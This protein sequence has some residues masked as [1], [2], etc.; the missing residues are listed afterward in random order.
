MDKDLPAVILLLM[1]IIFLVIV[2]MFVVSDI[3]QDIDTL[4]DRLTGVEACCIGA[5]G[6]R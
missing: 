1:T 2:A 3:K 4:S 6:K 5:N